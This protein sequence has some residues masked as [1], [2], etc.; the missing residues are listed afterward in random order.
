MHS[1]V[2]LKIWAAIFPRGIDAPMFQFMLAV[3]APDRA[4]PRS[5]PGWVVTVA[6]VAIHDISVAAWRGVLVVVN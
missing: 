2:S 4:F 1:D 6:R 5:I 3:V